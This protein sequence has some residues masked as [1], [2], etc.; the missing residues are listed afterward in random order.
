MAGAGGPGARAHRVGHTLVVI[1]LLLAIVGFVRGL[2]LFGRQPDTWATPGPIVDAV[3]LGVGLV[4]GIAGFIIGR[5]ALAR[6]RAT[7]ATFLTAKEEA[8]VVEAIHAAEKATSGEIRVHLCGQAVPDVMKEARATFERLGMTATSERNGVL[9]FVGVPDRQFAI[10]GD[11]GIDQK[12][13]PGFWNEVV[14]G[15]E[16]EF[17]RG[18][19]GGALVHGITRAGEALSQYFPPRPDDVDEL[20]DDVSRS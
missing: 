4:L 15:V 16:A 9:F 18:R 11:Q 19:F 5:R 3:V 20:P 2:L 8:A 17:R 13:P 7:P 12:V 14:Q 6:G 1:G 10:L